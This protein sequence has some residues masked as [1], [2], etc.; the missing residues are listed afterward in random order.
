MTHHRRLQPSPSAVALAIATATNRYLHPAA[1]TKTT[2]LSAPD[3]FLHGLPEKLR[4]LT[5]QDAEDDMIP[6]PNFDTHVFC[7][8]VDTIGTFQLD[9]DSSVDLEEGELYLLPFKPIRDLLL[10]QSIILI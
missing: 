3:S 6:A 9:Q 4:D 10:D 2:T 1:A 7:K 5:T 8:V